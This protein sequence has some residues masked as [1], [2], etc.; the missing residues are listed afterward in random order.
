M[1]KDIEVPKTITVGELRPH[2]AG[3]LSMPDDTLVVFGDGTLSFQRVK[4]RGPIEGRQ[5][6]QI[7]FN[8]PGPHTQAP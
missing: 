5:I 3:L 6:Q 8:E 1:E 2:L 4:S 7:E